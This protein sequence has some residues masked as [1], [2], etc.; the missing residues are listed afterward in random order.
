MTQILNKSHKLIAQF[1]FT[2]A[3]LAT[4][5]RYFFLMLVIINITSIFAN[6]KNAIGLI[7][8]A[9]GFIVI[10]NTPAFELNTGRFEALR[11]IFSSGEIKTKTITTEPRNETWALYTDIILDKLFFGNGYGALQGR[12]AGAMDIKVGVHNTYLMVLGESGII[13]FLIIV[14]LY[15]SLLFKSAKLFTTNPE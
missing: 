10:I 3:G 6:R 7:A 14:I 9:I 5:S 15:L 11:S 8:G 4:L 13:P 1:L 12:G 2:I